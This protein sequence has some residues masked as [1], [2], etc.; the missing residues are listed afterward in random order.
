VATPVCF[1]LLMPGDTPDADIVRLLDQLRER[2]RALDASYVTPL[3]RLSDRELLLE[4]GYPWPTAPMRHLTARTFDRERD[5]SR[6]ID[7]AGF[8]MRPSTYSQPAVFAMLRPVSRTSD[9]STPSAEDASWS[10]GYC[11]EAPTLAGRE[12][13][14]QLLQSAREIGFSVSVH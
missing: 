1:E 3:W 8:M 6:A 5:A 12:R 13:L 7:L 10:W 2:A 11:C 9:G 14:L 4:S